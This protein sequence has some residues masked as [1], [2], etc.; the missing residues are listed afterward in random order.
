MNDDES[1]TV[2]LI[3]NEDRKVKVSGGQ[4]FTVM[5]I[6]SSQNG[7]QSPNLLHALAPYLVGV[8]VREHGAALLGLVCVLLAL[9]G[10]TAEGPAGRAG[11]PGADGRDGEPGAVGEQGPMGAPG[12]PGA[13]PPIYSVAG[14]VET[15]PGGGVEQT[16]G[17]LC[18]AGDRVLGGG[19]IVDG[20]TWHGSIPLETMDGWL[21]MA[22]GNQA[23]SM[24]ALAIC[25][26][27]AP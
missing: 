13:M 21:C 4:R 3:C 19:C 9:V 12:A 7:D 10:C 24:Q 26:E 20:L 18:S 6:I 15:F 1:T 27:V 8:K 25:A 22:Q 5:L 14:D 11:E 23:G 16:A 2:S 17:V